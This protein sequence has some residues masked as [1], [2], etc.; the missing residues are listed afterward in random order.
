M[1]FSDNLQ[2]IRAQAGVTQEQLAEQL[3]V[4]RQSVS[5]WESGASFPEMDTL[6]RLC[7]LYDVKLDTLLRGSVEESR[8]SDTARYDHFMNRFALQMASSVSAIIAGVALMIFLSTL[9]SSDSFNMLTV[10][11]FM[12]IVTVSVVALWPAACNTTASAKSTRSS[13]ISIRK[14]KRMLSIR[15]SCGTSLAAS[16]PFCSAWCC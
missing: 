1:A 10:A 11:L 8:G 15:N 14:R 16:A 3:N 9:N 7:D 4:S 2:Y 6:L 12:L 5:K 13:R